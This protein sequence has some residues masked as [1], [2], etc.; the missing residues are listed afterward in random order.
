MTDGSIP[1]GKALDEFLASPRYRVGMKTELTGFR[2]RC[3]AD[4]PLFLAAG[5]IKGFMKG[6]KKATERQKRAETLEAFFEYAREKGWVSNNPAVG[7]IKKKEPKIEKKAPAPKK[8]E[9][10]RL[11]EEGRQKIKEEMEQLRIEKERVVQDV[12]DA[13]E[14]G[15]LKENAPYHAARERLA[16]IE[17]RLREAEA[18]LARAVPL[19]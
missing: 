11:S 16:M 5:E 15:D 2:R 10:I 14:D 7:L 8:A 1:L 17:G 13:R 4:C 12:K 19:E 3:G 18:I 6:V 9:P